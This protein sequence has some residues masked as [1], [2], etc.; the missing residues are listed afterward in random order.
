[1]ACAEHTYTGPTSRIPVPGR[2]K[3]QK[4]QL[5]ALWKDLQAWRLLEKSDGLQ[6]CSPVGPFY[7]P[8]SGDNP[9]SSRAHYSV[10]TCVWD[11]L[12]LRSL[13]VGRRWVVVY[14]RRP[15]LIMSF[16][17]PG[18]LDLFCHLHFDQKFDTETLDSTRMHRAFAVRKRRR[19]T[20]QYTPVH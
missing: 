8:S 5:A 6:Q 4:G 18:S 9:S 17:R 20:V 19:G 16:E 7:P 11:L 1:M 12:H 14:R 3:G 15:P 13:A 2:R 10:H